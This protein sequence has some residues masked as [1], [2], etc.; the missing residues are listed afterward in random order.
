MSKTLFLECAPP[1]WWLEGAVEN[2]HPHA[3][4]ANPD[5]LR[6]GAHA[7]DVD[8]IASYRLEEVVDRDIAGLALIAFGSLAV[9]MLVLTGV[10]AFGWLERLLIACGILSVL[11]IASLIEIVGVTTVRY[12]RV[13]VFTRSGRLIPFTATDHKETGELITFL[14]EVLGR[15]R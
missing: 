1:M 13:T 9:A 3:D 8:D 2:G 5:I 4:Y 11:G 12:L 14:E 10:V 15:G 7:V 6:L